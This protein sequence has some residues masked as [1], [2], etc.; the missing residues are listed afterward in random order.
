MNKVEP[1]FESKKKNRERANVR[2]NEKHHLP[3]GSENAS[4]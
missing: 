4:Y 3:R 1:G 2:A